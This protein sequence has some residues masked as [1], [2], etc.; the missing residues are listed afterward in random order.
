MDTEKNLRFSDQLDRDLTY[1]AGKKPSLAEL[2]V[3]LSLVAV[4]N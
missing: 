1:V 2:A 3:V 4:I